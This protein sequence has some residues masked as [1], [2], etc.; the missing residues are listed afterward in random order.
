MGLDEIQNSPGQYLVQQI[1]SNRKTIENKLK[2]C[3]N[4]SAES[5]T[6]E[7]VAKLEALKAEYKREYDYILRGSFIR[8]RKLEF[9]SKSLESFGFGESFRAW[10]EMFYNNISSSITNN[11]FSTP[12][13]NLKRGVRQGDPLSPSLFIIVLELLAISVR[14]D[15]QIRGIKVDGNELKLVISADD[16]TSF[17]RDRRSHLTLFNTIDLFSSYSGLCIN[18]D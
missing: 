12:S 5:P 3:E 18:Y 13:F 1:K 14:N 2:I 17:V 7:N 11:G 15:N 10:I 16:M 9:L 4:D 8:L 6:Q